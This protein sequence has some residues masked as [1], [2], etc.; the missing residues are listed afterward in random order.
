MQSMARISIAEIA[1]RLK[2]GKFGGQATVIRY[3]KRWCHVIHGG[4]LDG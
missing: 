2:D 1:R 4:N 3:F